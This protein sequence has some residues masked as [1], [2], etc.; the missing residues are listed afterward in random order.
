MIGGA[1][2]VLAQQ[3]AR[4][5]QRAIPQIDGRVQG[6]RFLAGDLEIEFQM[7]LQVLADAG[8]IVNHGNAERAQFRRG[9][10]ARQLQQLR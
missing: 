10:D 8:Q 5:D 2:A 3:P 4:A 1:Q 7:I 9:P 6:D